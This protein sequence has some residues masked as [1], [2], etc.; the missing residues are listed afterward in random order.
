MSW[1]YGPDIVIRQERHFDD[2]VMPCFARRPSGPYE[3]FER[4]VAARPEAE[5]LVAGDLRL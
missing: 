5:A 1:N 4:A 3:A 2:R